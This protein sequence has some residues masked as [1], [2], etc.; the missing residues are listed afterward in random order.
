M[1]HEHLELI[2]TV[3]AQ[4]AEVAQALAAEMI[5]TGIIPPGCACLPQEVESIARV[6]F[7]VVVE[8]IQSLI[9]CVC[10]GVPM[11]LPQDETTVLVRTFF[12]HYW[13]EVQ[14]LG[15][16]RGGYL[17]LNF[18]TIARWRKNFPC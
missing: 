16:M 6:I 2:R 11:P 5:T 12:F 4:Q 9:R 18:E 10:D 14:P 7:P 15:A 17:D 13:G 1:E 3:R 8:H